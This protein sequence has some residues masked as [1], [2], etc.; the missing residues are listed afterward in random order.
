MT[1]TNTTI[2]LVFVIVLLTMAMYFKPG[3]NVAGFP[4]GKESFTSVLKNDT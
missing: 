4:F 2:Y 3:L 1:K